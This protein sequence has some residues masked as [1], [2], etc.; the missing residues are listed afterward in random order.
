MSRL[1]SVAR[2]R[3][4]TLPLV[5]TAIVAAIP[6]VAVDP[7]L[8]YSDRSAG[9]HAIEYAV[10]QN[11]LQSG[12]GVEVKRD[13]AAFSTAL[14]ESAGSEVWVIARYTTTPPAYFEALRDFA[15]RTGRRVQF[16]LWN[17]AGQSFA[18]GVQVD[19][20]RC[21]AT[22]L[23]E[24]GHRTTIVSYSDPYQVNGEKKTTRTLDNL[25]WPTFA[26]VELRTV[27]RL[28]ASTWV[29]D[30]NPPIVAF[31]ADGDD[32]CA[33]ACN[34]ALRVAEA[35]CKDKRNRREADCDEAY[36]TDP[37]ERLACKRRV[38][39][40]YNNC[41]TEAEHDYMMCMLLCPEP[42][43]PGDIGG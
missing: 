23:L 32:T 42:P 22:W 14:N 3:G 5:L 27:T 39:D 17:D 7:V 13:V 12:P 29:T 19:A 4:K 40:F 26:G 9:T 37:T 41:L 31:A 35:G 36:P 24:A 21:N 18:P 11:A 30:G 34:R 25:V 6:A 15:I 16:F 43:P 10:S 20:S 8:I 2:M 1:S 38:S 33:A 28:A